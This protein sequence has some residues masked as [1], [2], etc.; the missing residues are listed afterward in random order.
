MPSGKINAGLLD[1][2][3]N[4][5][6]PF[7]NQLFGM[8]SGYVGSG[9]VKNQYQEPIRGNT[10]YHTEP[11]VGKPVGMEYASDPYN[12]NAGPAQKHLAGLLG[13]QVLGNVNV[14]T[15]NPNPQ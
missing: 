8:P 9:I 14:R 13:R 7:R 5:R 1:N 11:P 10:Y 2:V 12:P 6:K 4:D 3:M 15:Q